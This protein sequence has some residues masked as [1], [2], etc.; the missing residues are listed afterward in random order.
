M[1]IK[2]GTTWCD[3]ATK[4]A[5]KVVRLDLFVCKMT[6]KVLD[7]LS[8]KFGK[9]YVS[10]RFSSA[11][12]GKLYNRKNRLVCGGDQIHIWDKLL[13]SYAIKDDEPQWRILLEDIP[14]WKMADISKNDR[15]RTSKQKLTWTTTTS[16][17]DCLYFLSTSASTMTRG[18]GKHETSVMAAKGKL[19]SV[20]AATYVHCFRNRNLRTSAAIN[21]KQ[22]S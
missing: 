6:Q 14:Q 3:T 12:T 16:R 7:E 20:P 15:E 19:I 13:N 21:R 8:Q 17:S 22:D 11:T 2:M 4:S 10:H 1:A 9:V 18:S 5:R